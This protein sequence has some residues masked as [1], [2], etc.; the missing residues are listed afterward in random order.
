MEGMAQ[1]QQVLLLHT[2]R[3]RQWRLGRPC[4]PASSP[5]VRP[6]SPAPL[7]PTYDCSW[8]KGAPRT[9]KPSACCSAGTTLI[10]GRTGGRLRAERSAAA[11]ACLMAAPQA[12]A[13]PSVAPARRREP[14][15]RLR[16]CRWASVNKAEVREGAPV[17]VT[18]KT[19]FAWS[20]NPL[21]ISESPPP[22]R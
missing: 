20:C 11:A 7:S 21:R 12:A 8:A 13:E 3:R 22:P 14:R 5:L 9:A 1:G 6:A 18:A 2:W 15:L 16:R 10:W 17:V 19:L 4:L